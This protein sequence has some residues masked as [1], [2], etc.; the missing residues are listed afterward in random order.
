MHPVGV[1]ADGMDHF[2]A[3]AAFAQ[4][5]GR[6]D[7][8]LFR[9]HLKVDVVQQSH[10]T[11]EILIFSKSQLLRVPAHHPFHGQCMMYV[12]RVL[13]VFLQQLQCRLPCDVLFHNPFFSSQKYLRREDIN[14]SA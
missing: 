5:L 13:V 10:D 9:V 11:P 12:E 7:A 8:M 6:L 3:H 1:A 4:Q 2:F 14:I